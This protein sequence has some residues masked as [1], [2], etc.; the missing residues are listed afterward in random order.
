MHKGEEEGKKGVWGGEREGG[1]QGGRRKGG[2]EGEKGEKEGIMKERNKRKELKDLN[3]ITVL[4][5]YN[6]EMTDN[7]VII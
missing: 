2:R 6:V 5:W 3:T 1:R 4:T 7:E